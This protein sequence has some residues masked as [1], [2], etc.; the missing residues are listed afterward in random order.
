MV[1]GDGH[2]KVP[3]LVADDEAGVALAGVEPLAGHPISLDR[4]DGQDAEGL[5]PSGAVADGGDELEG[6]LGLADESRHPAAAAAG[7]DV[8]QEVVVVATHVLV[9]AQAKPDGKEVEDGLVDQGRHHRVD[10]AGLDRGHTALGHGEEVVGR[11]GGQ[12]LDAIVHCRVVAYD[13]YLDAVLDDPHAVYERLR[14]ESPV[15]FLEQYDAWFL[16]RFEDVWEALQRS[17]LS[18]AEGISPSQLLLGHPADPLMP[19]QMDPP[20]HTSV[21]RL[22]SDASFRPSRVQ[23]LEDDVRSRARSLLEAVDPPGFDAVRDYAAPL[24]MGTASELCGFPIEDAP[25]FIDW[26]NDFFHRRPGH[27]GETERAAAAGAHLFAYVSDHL[28]RARAQPD[29]MTSLT[30]LLM[31]T[32]VDGQMMSEAGLISTLVNMLI[33]AA[34]TFPKVFAACLVCLARSPDQRRLVVSRPELQLEAF[35]EALR[36]DTP[37]QFQGR[38]ITEDVEIGGHRMRRGQRVCFLFA[39]A[40]RDPREFADPDR[41]HVERRPRRMVGFGHGI[42]VCLGMHLARME[43]RVTLHEFLRRWP[44]YRVDFESAR[45]AR[46]EY[47][48]GWLRLP[49]EVDAVSEG[50]E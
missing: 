13:P 18:V 8:G 44:D 25:L 11:G 41:Y 31:T 48:R 27:K 19:S 43:A 16:A 46:T 28:A 50:G 24:A 34:D 33:A 26:V 49:V 15:V 47:V 36:L 30:R 12:N 23:G 39:S 45:Y 9:A 32:P 20:R 21:R 22:L 17:E 29:T 14:E 10:V 5:D 37:T 3:Q 1:G 38:T 7:D 35:H 42:H 2:Q 40:N 6:D 4:L